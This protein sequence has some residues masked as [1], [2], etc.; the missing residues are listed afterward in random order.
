VHCYL[1]GIG[2]EIMANSDNVLRCGLTPKHV[3]VDELLKI[4]DFSPLAEPR[5]PADAEGPARTF[6]V[7]VADFALSRM[8]LTAAAGPYELAR[9]TPQIVLCTAGAGSVAAAAGRVELTPGH[10]A[11]VAATDRAATVHGAGRVFVAKLGA[12]GL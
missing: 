4:T 8:D 12:S 5:W 1:R 6:R 2:V 11:F 3:D 10:A 9:D 7:P